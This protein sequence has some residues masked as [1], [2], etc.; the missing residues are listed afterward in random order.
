[1]YFGIESVFAFADTLRRAPSLSLRAQVLTASA[2]LL[3]VWTVACL[4][5]GAQG[6]EREGILECQGGR[7][8]RNDASTLSEG[9]SPRLSL[10][11][12]GRSMRMESPPLYKKGYF[13]QSG[14]QSRFVLTTTS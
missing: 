10:R 4:Y 3:R 8:L 13:G 7:I 6:Y 11:I 2:H 5:I 1:M 14:R 9:R 12:R